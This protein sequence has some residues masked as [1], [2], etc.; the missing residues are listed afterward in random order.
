MQFIDCA[1]ESFIKRIQDKKIILF[2]ASTGWDYYLS[3]IPNLGKDVLDKA[4]YVVDNNELLVGQKCEIA[5]R[6]FVIKKPDAICTNKDIAILITVRF[7]Y[8]EA[9]CE[10][11]LSYNLPNLIECFSLQLLLGAKECVNNSCVDNYFARHTIKQ[12]PN[13]IHSF[14]FS[15]EEKPDSYKKCIESWHRYCPDFEIY[16]WNTKNYDV[17]QN[18][19]MKQ[20]YEKRKWAFVSDYA[21]LDVISKYGGIYLDMDVE[22]LASLEKLLCTS[23][24]FCKQNDGTVDLGSGFGAPPNFWL[25][26]ELLKEYDNLRF[27]SHDN[28]LDLLPQPARLGYIFRKYGLKMGHDSENMNDI[29]VLSNDYITCISGDPAQWKF[30]GTELGIHWH[31]GGWL[32]ASEREKAAI[33]VKMKNEIEKKYFEK[34]IEDDFILRC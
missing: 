18:L 3:V 28:K 21:R 29:L 5:G 25:I 6:V 20:A 2:G 13:K 32:Q 7:R 9:I 1:Y 15:G 34:V 14:W 4:L 31:N 23:A 33:D 30:K 10:Q 22:L 24:F 19:Y 27:I 11:L 17:E 8:Y 16:E 12:I 26:T